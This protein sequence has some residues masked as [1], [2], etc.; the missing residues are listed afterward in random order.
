MSMTLEQ[1]VTQLQQEVFNLRALVGANF[2]DRCSI[3]FVLV[4]D[5]WLGELSCGNVLVDRGCWTAGLLVE[6]LQLCVLRN[7]GGAFVELRFR[8]GAMS[9]MMEQVVTQLQLALFTLRA[10]VAAEYGLA[11]VVRAI[12]NLATAHIRKDTP[13]LVDVKGLGRPKEFIGREKDF[14]QWSKKTE[15]F[16]AGVIRESEMMLEWAAEQPTEITTTAIDLEFLPTDANKDRGVQNLE[17]VLQQMHTALMALPS[18]EADDF[19]A[20][21]PKNPSEAW[22]RLQKRYDPT[23]GGRKRNLLRT[24]ISPG[25]CSLLERQAGIELWESYEAR[26][27]K[28]LMDKLDD[29]IKLAGLEALVPEELEKHLILNSNRLRTFEEARLVVVTYVGEIWFKDP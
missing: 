24:I 2:G 28:K 8:G 4:V 16:F 5:S 18:Y 13:S 21:S 17:F 9:M 14:Q 10:Q 22:R 15:A 7:T 23:T 20:N 29:E 11:D 3:L 1:V 27:E 26:Y 12:N 19:V 6:L 25:R